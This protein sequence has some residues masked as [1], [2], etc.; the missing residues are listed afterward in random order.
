MDIVTPVPNPKTPHIEPMQVEKQPSDSDNSGSVPPT[1]KL[2]KSATVTTP[3]L[4]TPK[5]SVGFA[6][7]IKTVFRVVTAK[8]T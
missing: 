3:A 2:A 8:L 1:Q 6:P 7:S 4:T 5:A